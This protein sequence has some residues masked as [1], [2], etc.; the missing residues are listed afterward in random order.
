MALTSF[1]GAIAFADFG[2]G[3]GLTVTIASAAARHDRRAMRAAVASAFVALTLIAAV[4]IAA[5]VLAAPAVNWR[6][7]F[8]LRL[9]AADEA[10]RSVVVFAICLVAGLPFAVAS[11]VQLGLQQSHKQL[12]WTAFGALLGAAAVS[13]AI[14]QSLPLHWAV[15]AFAAGPLVALVLNT[16]VE[17]AVSTPDLAPLPAYAHWMVTRRL[18][19]QGTYFLLQQICGILSFSCDNFIIARSL[20]ATAIA[21]FSLAQK[22]FSLPLMTQFILTPFWPAFAEAVERGDYRWATVTLRRICGA[23]VAVGLAISLPLAIFGSRIIHFWA[24]SDLQVT[25]ALL[26][27]FPFWVVNALLVGSM[28]AALNHGPTLPRHVALLGLTTASSLVLKALLVPRLGP[29]GVIWAT[30]LAYSLIHHPVA[31]PMALSATRDR[32]FR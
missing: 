8:N 29:S 28:N 10:G 16:V 27:P 17:F 32:S 14:R 19:S 4:V 9:V 15:L 5:L 23:S 18:A 30:V 11:R 7:L 1:T 24:G 13:C 22:L 12:L 21:E 3:S 20:G 6:T 25:A 2:I 31:L 26:A